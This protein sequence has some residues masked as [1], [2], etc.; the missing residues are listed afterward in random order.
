[1]RN[2]I[3][4]VILQLLVLGQC[5]IARADGGQVRV[6]QNHGDVKLTIFT[7]PSPLRAGPID[8]S[9]LLQDARTGQTIP[10]ADVTVALTPPNSSQP[11]ICVRATAD[12]ATNKLLRAALL[13]LPSPGDWKFRIE[14]VV[15]PADT[16]IAATFTAIAA[17]PLPR[18]LTIWPWFTW[19]IAAV[20]L[21]AVHRTLVAPRI[22]PA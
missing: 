19:P 16:L 4:F 3:S 13:D 18:W 12:A 7:S 20:A 11:P 9:V 6:M 2:L 1:M 17:E 15:P 22:K 5:A 21:F 14:C 8:V 10:D